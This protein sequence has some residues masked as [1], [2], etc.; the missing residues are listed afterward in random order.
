MLLFFF[1]ACTATDDAKDDTGEARDS[2]PEQDILTTEL[3]L[4]VGA[5]TGEATLTVA[6]ARRAE[7]VTLDVSGLSLTRVTVDGEV[8]EPTITDG[9]ASVPV[10]AGA[11]PVTI[12][13]AYG[14]PARDVTTFD[15]WM[16]D[17]GVSFLWPDWCG[18]LFPCD[19]GTVDGVTFGMTVTG[20]DPSLT[21]VYPTTT[22]TDGPSYMPGMAIGEYD[23]LDLGTTTAGTHLRAWYFPDDRD[24][25]VEGTLHLLG[26]YDFYE[27]TYGPYAFGPEAGTVEV[28]WGFDSYGG[29]E[30]HPFVHVGMLDFWNEEA[31][32]HEAGHAWY[33]DGVRLEC[34]EDFV[35][36]EGTT[37]YITARAMESQ[38]VDLWAPYVNLYLTPICEGKQPNAVCL[39][40]TCGEVDMH[41]D[42]L[43]SLAPYMKGACFY[44][45]VADLIGQE[46]LDRIIADFYQANV[47]QPAKMQEMIHLIEERSTPEEAA[48]I[49][50]FV[51]D[52]L[53][54]LACP[55]DYAQRCKSHGG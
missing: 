50:G 43:W 12:R 5:L 33:G 52:W 4:D 53:L 30:H 23:V 8:V 48:A 35:L 54:K 25:A 10:P 24:V 19:P 14:F 22:V 26:A 1:L 21:A 16:P 32:V 31:Q 49:E 2:N 15:G 34:W 41:T 13:A 42:P 17:L 55:E 36:S 46:K 51:D 29:M 20:Y 40:D 45:D 37:T 27:Q 3:A 39:P 38:G 7:A 47:N 18:N 28:D 11:D 44:E 6:P 9:V